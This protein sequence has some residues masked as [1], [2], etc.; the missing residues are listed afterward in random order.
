MECPGITGRRGKPENHDPKGRCE[1]E[2]DEIGGDQ[3][4]EE[5]GSILGSESAHLAEDHNEDEHGGYQDEGVDECQKED[6]EWIE[7]K[8]NHG[9]DRNPFWWG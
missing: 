3:N 7:G 1:D 8:L 2:N 5:Y 4:A 6:G 9:V